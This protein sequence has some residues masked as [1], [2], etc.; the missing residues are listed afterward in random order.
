MPFWIKMVHQD[1]FSL[2]HLS[3]RIPDPRSVKM[4]QFIS[5][6][7][8]YNIYIYFF[9]NNFNENDCVYEE[10]THKEYRTRVKYV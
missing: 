5:P 8:I 7:I 10:M 2:E 9:L 4:L 3:F 6:K 1:G